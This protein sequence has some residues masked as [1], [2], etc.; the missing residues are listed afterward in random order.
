[1][2]R[3]A[4]ILALVGVWAVL[5]AG[6]A[7]DGGGE[8]AAAAPA[9]EAAAPTGTGGDSGRDGGAG[10]ADTDDVRIVSFAFV[11][12]TVRAKVGQK[13][14]WE[15]QDP[16]VTHTVVA[17]DGSF[18]SGRLHEGDEFSHVFNRAGTFAYWCGLHA[19]MRGTVKVSG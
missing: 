8:G 1:M 10:D 15:H 4:T 12:R 3:A 16:G 18:R 11:P 6:C 9:S 17:R 5:A 2:R 19:S 7:G 13:V 14:K